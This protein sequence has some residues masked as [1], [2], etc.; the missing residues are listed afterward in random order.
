MKGVK[1]RGKLGRKMGECSVLE[2]NGMC[3]RREWL[4]ELNFV[5]KIEKWLKIIFNCKRNMKNKKFYNV[6]K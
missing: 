2:I 4:N 6:I 3:L 1:R 5:D